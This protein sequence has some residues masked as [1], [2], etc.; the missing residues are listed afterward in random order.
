M[1]IPTPNKKTETKSEFVSRCM[2]DSTMNK[3]FPDQ[4]QRAAICY[5]Q[6]SKRKAKAAYVVTAAGEEFA[7]FLVDPD[8][9]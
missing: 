1:P 8:T 6:W 5:R 3:E 4:S 9:E 7:T 2:G